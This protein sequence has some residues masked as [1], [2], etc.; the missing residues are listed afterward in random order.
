M[1]VPANSNAVGSETAPGE[2]APCT[3]ASRTRGLPLN[4]TWVLHPV[5]HEGN[6]SVI[7]SAHRR[8]VHL[9]SKGGPINSQTLEF[10]WRQLDVS[11]H[12]SSKLPES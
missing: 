4:P 12:E 1:R 2:A 5:H 11:D 10:A 6:G 9:M 7:N 3:R 8:H